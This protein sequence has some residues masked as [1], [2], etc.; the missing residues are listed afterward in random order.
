MGIKIEIHKRKFLKDIIFVTGDKTMELE[1]LVQNVFAIDSSA[2]IAFDA[3]ESAHMGYE[4]YDINNE[5]S[6]DKIIKDQEK[7]IIFGIRVEFAKGIISSNTNNLSGYS[8][9]PLEE[10]SEKEV[11][12]L[13]EELLK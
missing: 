1:R 12:E 8:F 11:E 13:F 4:S 10:M 6:L 5:S 7:G 2:K 9:S 3:E